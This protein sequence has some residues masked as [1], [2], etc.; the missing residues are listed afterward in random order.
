MDFK[1]PQNP[2]IVPTNPQHGQYV[3]QFAPELCEFIKQGLKLKTYR[4]GDKYA[5]LKPG[6]QV[7]LR[8]YETSN[9]ISKAE[10]T[11]VEKV[12]F[13][14]IPLDLGGHEVYES[15]EHQRK[16]FSSYYKYVGREIADEDSFLVISYLLKE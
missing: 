5:Y 7:E 2:T 9:L 8:E 15:K 10:I 1:A 3:I 12:T 13:K 6:D 11:S 4:F 14:E 16:V